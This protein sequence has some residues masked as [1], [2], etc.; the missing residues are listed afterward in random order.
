MN[1]TFKKLC[2]YCILPC[3]LL[4]SL[5]F[6]IFLPV[7]PRYH[8]EIIF[9]VQKGQGNREIGYNLEQQGFIR[10]APVFRIYALTIGISKKLQAGAYLLSPGMSAN[11]IGFKI[12]RGD[13]IKQYFTILEGWNRKDIESYLQEK[14]FTISIPLEF[15]GYLFPDTYEFAQNASSKEIIDTM[16]AN[17]NEK[18]NQ[19][20]RNETIKQKKTIQQIVTMASLI[21]KEVRTPEDKVIVS[22]ILWK[23][24]GVGMPLQVD[25]APDTYKERGLPKNPIASPGLESIKAALY[26]KAT[27]YW[28]YLSKPNG[29]TVFSKT[30]Q[31]HIIAKARYLH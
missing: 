22:G 14:G 2:S 18:F 6:F 9:I 4:L 11:A 19:T 1:T 21:E 17:F 13:I 3:V 27:A 5:W 24:L 23:R 8:Q 25:V 29:I 15:E 31:E 12:A 20:L 30:L 7:H 28:F 10:S 26:P 16:Q